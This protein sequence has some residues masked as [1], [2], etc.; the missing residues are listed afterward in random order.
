[1]VSL[2]RRYGFPI[3]L[4]LV[5]GALCTLDTFDAVIKG[6]PT[7]FR[8]LFLA[9][10]AVL[11]VFIEGFARGAGTILF[12]SSPSCGPRVRG[13]LLLL[14]LVGFVSY[15]LLVRNWLLTTVFKV[16]L[17]LHFAYGQQLTPG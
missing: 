12:P 11:A 17:G 10:A 1:M 13:V 8:A 7:M 6:H 16:L 15:H 3:L 5:A 4:I 2:A 14:P 9:D